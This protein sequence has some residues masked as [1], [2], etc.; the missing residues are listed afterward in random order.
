MKISKISSTYKPSFKARKTTLYTDFDETF[1]PKNLAPIRNNIEGEKQSLVTGYNKFFSQFQK[2]L[3][4]KKGLFEINISTGRRLGNKNGHSFWATY[5]IMR[6]AGVKFP[7]I[8]SVITVEGGDIFAFNAKNGDLIP[9]P[10]VEKL[11]IIKQK[12]GWDRSVAENI[13]KETAKEYKEGY[14]VTDPRSSHK[15]NIVLDNPDKR[16]SFKDILKAKFINAGIQA[17]VH[18][19]A[20]VK[21]YTPDGSKITVPG[22]KIEPLIDGQ[23]IKKDFDVKLAIEKAIKNKD[24][25]IAAGDADNDKE[26]LNLFNYLGR[27]DIKTAKDVTVL[28]KE[29]I[30]KL[31]TKLKNLPVGIVYVDHAAESASHLHA[32]KLT[33]LSNFMKE[34]KK[35]FPDRIKIIPKSNLTEK[36]YLLDS[37][38]DLISSYENKG[39]I[40]KIKTQ[41][42]IFKYT[43]ISAA[44]TATAGLGYYVAKSL[45]KR[46]ST[47]QHGKDPT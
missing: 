11:D 40:K 6:K 36:N 42:R 8:N 22:I 1:A 14:R 5:N 18:R 17:D 26:M 44:V 37:I 39:A 34:Q 13:V 28:D 7:Q 10:L 15:L 27:K 38:K 45:L 33:A 16:S 2:F 19:S 24:F 30:S 46:H 20:H 47:K 35:I 25:V 41:S 9:Q 43:V 23:K 29:T 31:K 3:D 4:E 21:D 32:D 12:S